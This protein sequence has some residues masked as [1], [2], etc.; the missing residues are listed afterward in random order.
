MSYKKNQV[1]QVKSVASKPVVPKPIV[2]AKTLTP[3][4]EMDV[5][6]LIR[7]DLNDLTHFVVNKHYHRLLTTNAF[8][9]QW[10]QYHYHSSE[11]E[12][13]EFLA[14]I[15]NKNFDLFVVLLDDALRFPLV[16]LYDSYYTKTE[17]I[18]LNYRATAALSVIKLL[19]TTFFWQMWLDRHELT[20]LDEARA[21]VTPFIPLKTLLSKLEI[22]DPGSI[23]M[24]DEAVRLYNTMPDDQLVKLVTFTDD[25]SLLRSRFIPRQEGL[26]HARYLILRP[27]HEA[28]V[29]FN[30]TTLTFVI[31]ITHNRK[32]IHS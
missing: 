19:N 14:K 30:K 6:I 3:I 7:L 28:V 17:N 11:T 9:C 23:H 2:N 20:A 4:N 1:W 15:S 21:T 22:L 29:Y 16:R 26:S 13:C 24:G 18:K 10:L 31:D 32:M 8:W 27:E 12:D 5:E 25:D